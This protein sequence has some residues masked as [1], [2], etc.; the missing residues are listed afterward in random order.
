MIGIYISAHP[1]DDFKLEIDHF[2]KG[3]LS[4]LSKDL[5]KIK[6]QELSIPVI[7]TGAQD[8]KSKK[9]KPYGILEV[10]DYYA[11]HSF[12]VFGDDYVKKLKAYFLPGQFLLINGKATT[13]KWSKDEDDLEFKITSIELLTELRENKVKEIT[14]AVRNEDV[15]DVFIKKITT[16]L[17]QHQG[18]CSFN[19]NIKDE[20]EGVIKLSSRSNR[21]E[22][23]DD[24][25]ACLDKLPE[26]NYKLN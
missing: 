14:L 25:L 12:F 17:A 13:K 15:N 11:S 3:N 24:F 18:K 8:R 22:M 21:V 7:C 4:L 23:S 6:G 2:A 19:I 5:T 1:L 16:I 20:N 26:V 9:D 10:E